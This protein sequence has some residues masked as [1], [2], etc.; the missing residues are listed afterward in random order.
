MITALKYRNEERLK[1]MG[2][3][4][5]LKTVA[6]MEIGS[7][8]VRMGVY[9]Q[10]KDDR[11]YTCIDRLEHPLRIGHE[12]FTTGYISGETI[13]KLSAILTDYFQVLTEYGI[14]RYLLFATTALRE[15][16][17]RMYVMDQLQIHNHVTVKVLE[18]GEE[19]GL[20]YYT[21][22][23]QLPLQETA[24][25]THIG[26]GS[27]GMAVWQEKT[28]TIVQT[29]NIGI[30]F[31]KLGDTLRILED[32]TSHFYSVLEE[33]VAVYFQR[34]AL[35]LDGQRFNQ[36]ILTGRDLDRLAVLCD[37]QPQKQNYELSKS[38][39]EDIYDEVKN[40]APSV[41]ARLK[42][43]DEDEAEQV[44]PMLAL[45]LRMMDFTQTE[46]ITVS[47]MDI[48]DILAEQL[49]FPDKRKSFTAFQRKSALSCCRKMAGDYMA[50]SIHG[51]RVRHAAL[52]LFDELK[53]WHGIPD[54]YRIL[55]EC[56]A[57]LHEVGNQ[58]NAEKPTLSAFSLIEQAYFYG[59]NRQQTL[60]IARIVRQG[61]RNYPAP[62]TD[63]FI[64]KTDMWVQKLSAI[65]RIADALDESRKG[66]IEKLQVKCDD[67]YLLLH[68][69]VLDEPLLEKWAL[70][71]C[72]AYVEHILGIRIKFT[73][74]SPFI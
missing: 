39:L 2:I 29:G 30:G 53:K 73:Y 40:I 10:V 45:Y 54:K 57:V 42:R 71:E 27:L 35:Q 28:K 33:Y 55:L 14:K 52:Q 65:L 22:C 31:L 24:L 41:L 69:A 16:K 5:T 38:A 70:L 51:E 60:L 13:R 26:T 1:N 62:S 37:L 17:N 9:Q 67:G 66:K 68:A 58:F 7:N 64:D 47:T 48:I 49:L 8:L 25:F 46:K 59:I 20:V 32:Q 11:E 21:L 74:K 18:N 61:D 6:V 44:L 12:V 4:R 63:P 56:A 3:K 23:H 72:G 36:L 19:S 34:L 15:A 50:D 43:M